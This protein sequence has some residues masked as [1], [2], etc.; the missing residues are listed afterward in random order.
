MS[1]CSKAE[2]PGPS[3]LS[4]R[5]QTIVSQPVSLVENYTG[6]VSSAVQ[7]S[8]RVR[9]RLTPC[10]RGRPGPCRRPAPHP[11]DLWSWTCRRPAG[12]PVVRGSHSVG[13]HLDPDHLDR[14]NH[15]DHAVR[16]GLFINT[17]TETMN[18]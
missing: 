9:Q 7:F 17:H 8:V 14:R 18:E 6:C 2:S 4:S 15:R 12:C 1:R 3:P 13:P 10:C 16:R 11:G 5:L